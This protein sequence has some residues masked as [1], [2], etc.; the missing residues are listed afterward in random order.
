MNRFRGISATK[1][2]FDQHKQ[3]YQEALKN[4][5]YEYVLKWNENRNGNKVKRKTRKKQILYYNP[6]FSMSIKTKLG[7]EFINLVKK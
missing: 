7:K 6:P 3:I 2:D 4:A 5:G 1:E